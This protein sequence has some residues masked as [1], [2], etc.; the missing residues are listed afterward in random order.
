MTAEYVYTVCDFM[1]GVP[2]AD[3]P[4]Q[5]DSLPQQ[6]N[7]DA[8]AEGLAVQLDDK[9]LDK[10]DPER[11]TLPRRTSLFVLRNGRPVWAGV[12]WDRKY[13]STTCKL[14]LQ[15]STVESWYRRRAFHSAWASPVAWNQTWLMGL[16]IAGR[17]AAI[18]VG[19]PDSRYSSGVIGQS[20]PIMTRIPSIDP[21]DPYGNILSGT[22]REVGYQ[23]GQ[24]VMDAM[25]DLAALT[26]GVDFTAQPAFVDGK[27]GWQ[28]KVGYPARLYVPYTTT[29]LRF[30]F[31]PGGNIDSYIE[32]SSGAPA[33]TAAIGIGGQTSG[34]VLA[35]VADNS[36]ALDA[37]WPMLDT[38]VSHNDTT[39]Q[40]L[41]D[42]QTASDLAASPPD[43]TAITWSLQGDM[44]P[45]FGSYELGDEALFSGSDHRFRKRPDGSAGLARL[46][47]IVGW[48]LKPPT[49]DRPELVEPIT[50][51][52]QLDATP[53]YPG[54]LRNRLRE[55][56]R[57]LVRSGTT[58]RT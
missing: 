37:G 53:R 34:T 31:G 16:L 4:C 55:I 7:T 38:V 42:T 50:N 57:A 26:G 24:V 58:P 15:C 12:I 10:I 47:R 40:S 5:A 9:A 41:L 48:N 13:D 56:E 30:T 44:D 20:P 17:I 8:T 28:W 32:D 49:S 21:G 54:T 46:E 6:L 19:N 29:G 36:A 39:S 2:I 51:V 3:L 43:A 25:T 11:A 33:C 14:E 52:T 18:E 1:T 22:L 23:A 27:Y 35:S 45:Q